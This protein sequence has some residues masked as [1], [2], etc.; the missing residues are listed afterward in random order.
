[1][2]TI[3]NFLGVHARIIYRKYSEQFFSVQKLR[4]SRYWSP[5]TTHAHPSFGDSSSNKLEDFHHNLL[6]LLTVQ[7]LLLSGF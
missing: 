3:T 5:S 6:I 7:I 2:I 4:L 1:M